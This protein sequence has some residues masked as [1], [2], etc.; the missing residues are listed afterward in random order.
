MTKSLRAPPQ[1]HKASEKADPHTE[2]VSV[3]KASLSSGMLTL[4]CKTGIADCMLNTLPMYMTAF[5]STSGM[6][7]GPCRCTLCHM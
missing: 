3:A 2:H 4:D 6:L 1:R 7:L 5:S